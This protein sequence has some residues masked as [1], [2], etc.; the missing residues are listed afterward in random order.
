[1]RRALDATGPTTDVSVKEAR[2]IRPRPL[3]VPHRRPLRPALAEVG[4]AHAGSQ[5]NRGSASSCAALAGG[6]NRRCIMRVGLIDGPV[7]LGADSKTNSSTALPV[8]RAA[9]IKGPVT[10]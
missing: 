8:R 7:L 1:M 3:Q 5:G 10:P 4:R 2:S 9:G 6:V